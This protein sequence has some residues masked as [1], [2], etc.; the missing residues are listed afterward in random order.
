MAGDVEVVHAGRRRR[1]ADEPCLLWQFREELL[2]CDLGLG[3]AHPVGLV[4][5]H[6]AVF[7]GR[8]LGVGQLDQLGVGHQVA[9]RDLA[10]GP[11][12]LYGLGVQGLV[13]VGVR[14]VEVAVHDGVPDHLGRVQVQDLPVVFY[15]LREEPGLAEP[16]GPD[17]HAFPV[18]AQQPAAVVQGALLF[19]KVRHIFLLSVSFSRRIRPRPCLSGR[20]RAPSCAAGQSSAGP[21]GTRAWHGP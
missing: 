11:A 13:R 1:G 20:W 7:H 8:D 21:P 18:F 2:A 3:A 9:A 17:Q 5:D 4:A 6:Q 19:F 10:Y 15:E 14:Q 16:G 12:G